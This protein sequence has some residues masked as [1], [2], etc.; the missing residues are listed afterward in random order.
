MSEYFGA[1]RGQGVSES[2]VS[3]T[4]RKQADRQASSQRQT[5]RQLVNEKEDSGV[6]R[7]NGGELGGASQE[8][9]SDPTGQLDT[10]QG[11][12]TGRA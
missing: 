7:K 5:G 3:R 8:G 2:Q 6:R 10:S 9:A 4:G 12:G 1:N 11:D